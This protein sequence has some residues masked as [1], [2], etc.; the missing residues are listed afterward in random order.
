MKI[1]IVGDDT[2]DKTDGV[3]QY[4]LTVGR[5]LSEQGHEVHYLVGETRRTDLPHLHS[6]TRNV[7]VRFN[8]NRL[9]IPL[10][11]NKRRLKILL[12][13]E[14]FDVLYVQMP[15]SPFLAGRIVKAAGTNTTV[16][17]IFH[18][19]PHT[20]LTSVGTRLLRLWLSRSIKR[21]DS[22]LSVSTAAQAF[23]K[24]AFRID[25]Q[26]VPNA[27]PLKSFFTAKPFPEYDDKLVVLF[28]GRLVERKGCGYFLQAVAKLYHEERWPEGAIVLISGA[29]PLAE[30]LQEYVTREQL[31]EVVTFLGYTTE[32][33]KPRYMAS[34]DVTVYPSTGGESFGIVLIESMA[35]SRGAVLAGN[36]A[37]YASVMHPRPGSLFNPKDI[38]AFAEIL[39]THLSGK[40]LRSAAHDWQ[41]TYV[42]QYDVSVVGKQLVAV[43]KEALRKRRS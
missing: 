9:S 5:W 22:F 7:K 8:G 4:I 32:D 2:L 35:A 42:K 23:S 40:K 34:A 19:L 41:Q 3:E 21:F 36:N 25:S 14:N 24:K 37:G 29:G 43:F 15:Y 28:H 26:F 18:I 10:P 30:T 1:G 17:G 31:N 39:F 6:L 13:K 38:P 20:W 33:D 27:S 12:Q 16:V 11:T